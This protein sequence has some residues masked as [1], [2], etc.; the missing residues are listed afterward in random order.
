MLMFKMPIKKEIINKHFLLAA[1]PWGRCLT[2]NAQEA[3]Q[4][5]PVGHTM[6]MSVP[7][8][9]KLPSMAVYAA[10]GEAGGTSHISSLQALREILMLFEIKAVQEKAGEGLAK[11]QAPDSTLW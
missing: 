2:P 7:L 11:E 1:E 9:S 8:C 10:T 3:V 5:A 6:T 4:P